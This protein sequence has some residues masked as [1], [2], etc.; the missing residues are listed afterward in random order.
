[1][2]RWDLDPWMF[3]QANLG[4]YSGNRFLLGDLLEATFNK[5]AAAYNLP[6]RNLTQKQA[7]ELMKRRM[8]YDASGVDGTLIPCESITLSVA[9]TAVVPL[10]GVASGTTETYGGQTIS[11]VPVTAGTAKTIPVTC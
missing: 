11:N 8:A 9:N 7:G 6:V 4:R 10:T 1:M 5:Y 3:H 2:L